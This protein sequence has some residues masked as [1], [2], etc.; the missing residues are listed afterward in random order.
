MVTLCSRPANTSG[1][2]EGSGS[3]SGAKQLDEQTREFISSEITRNIL[4]HTLVI[5]GL[6]KEGILEI[7]NERLHAFY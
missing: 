1:I 7:L 3:G 4:D 5:F 6:V 2:G